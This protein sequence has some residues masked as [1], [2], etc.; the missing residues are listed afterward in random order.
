[1]MLAYRLLRSVVLKTPRRSEVKHRHHKKGSAGGALILIVFA[2]IVG[3]PGVAWKIVCG[4]AILAAWMISIF[5]KRAPPQ[6]KP[7]E[8]TDPRTLAQIIAEQRK[9][10]APVL[11]P[12]APRPTPIRQ[13]DAPPRVPF[14]SAA[15]AAAER[16]AAPEEP[17]VVQR[18]VA[19]VPATP[20]PA[21]P[22]A[23]K[24]TWVGFDDT[25]AIAKWKLPR[26]GVY[27]GT[28]SGGASD[29]WRA[30]PALIDPS[31][32]VD[33]AH[34]D[35]PGQSMGY[36]PSYRTIKPN[37]RATF[38]VYIHSDRV[39]PGVGLG[40]V[41]L[42]FYGLERRLLLD[43]C[44][45]PVARA[46]VPA[47]LAEIQRLLIVY[48]PIS[49]SFN[50]YASDLHALGSAIYA[51]ANSLTAPITQGQPGSG[52]LIQMGRVLG[53]GDAVPASLALAWAA[54]AASAPRI[55]EWRSVETEARELFAQSYQRAFGNG[56]QL[57]K[58][59]GVLNV[60]HHGAA[61]NRTG[62]TISLN[63]PDPRVIEPRLGQL[64]ILFTSVVRQLES[65]AHLRARRADPLAEAALMPSGLRSQALP[66][67][68]ENLK[69]FA[70]IAVRD[71]NGVISVPELRQHAGLDVSQKLGKRDAMSCAKALESLGFG[72]EPDVRQGGT[73]GKSV[74][75]FPLEANTS[76]K[77]AAT[78]TAAVG[79]LNLAF[80]MANA[81]GVVTAEEVK[82]ALDHVGDLFALSAC[83]RN[84]LSARLRLLQLAPPSMTKLLGSARQLA[85]NRREAVAQLVVGIAHA[86]GRVDPAEIKLLERIYKALDLDPA[87]VPSDIHRYATQSST[88]TPSNTRGLDTAAIAAKMKE[89]DAVQNMLGRI[90]AE[91]EASIAA[92]AASIASESRLGL[93]AACNTLLTHIL[94]STAPIIARTEWDEWCEPLGLMPDGAVENI[95]DA[96]FEHLDGA[97]LTDEGDH[98]EIQKRACEAL[99]AHMKEVA[100]A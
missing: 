50:R 79:V 25:Q 47:I 82:S 3:A 48:G 66:A 57:P 89:T 6:P 51:D 68:L 75:V 56:I 30:E 80:A 96:A 1:M 94:A 43:A 31:L 18:A 39:R 74:V 8:P 73:V 5:A 88:A 23:V 86:D 90:F 11:R 33:A 34:L 16:K 27:I 97:L 95:N 99:R 84:R 19:P 13:P 59:A 83:D 71:R 42:Y 92:P 36:W 85:S 9:S 72:L 52:L 44:D 32:P 10:P 29:P 35:Y 28:P 37:E 69:Q 49:R 77:P 53:A 87:K 21:P 58:T 100:H 41:F 22:P 60:R 2:L 17:V 67:V 46:E 15:L 76:P 63:I 78:Y 12:A 26:G 93:D 20:I 4:V 70:S 55:A 54:S 61:F 14:S 7:S 64:P 45:D 38:I 98:L 65:L 40:Y 24:P 81:D 62:M 91:A